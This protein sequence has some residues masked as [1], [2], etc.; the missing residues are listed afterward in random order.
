MLPFPAVSPKILPPLTLKQDKHLYLD[1]DH[2][3]GFVCLFPS[4]KIEITIHDVLFASKKIKERKFEENTK[5]DN[6][7]SCTT[8]NTFCSLSGY[9]INSRLL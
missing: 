5:F 4:A 1:I 2:Q 3:T 8:V 6:I 7:P 9:I